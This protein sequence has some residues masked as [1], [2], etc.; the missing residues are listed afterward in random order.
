MNLFLESIIRYNELVVESDEEM[1]KLE[2]KAS[3]GDAQAKEALKRMKI[4]TGKISLAPRKHTTKLRNRDSGELLRQHSRNHIRAM[5]IMDRN[6]HPVHSG[7]LSDESM[8]KY[9]R[10]QTVIAR[11][12]NRASADIARGNRPDI[13]IP[14][15]RALKLQRAKARMHKLQPEN[16]ERIKRL[17]DLAT[18]AR[19]QSMDRQVMGELRPRGTSFKA[20]ADKYK[21]HNYYP[22]FGRAKW[23]KP[24]EKK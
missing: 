1:R 6:V 13:A 23:K 2:R 7:D 8:N 20:L 16:K 12:S 4:R 14:E 24:E 18:R 5:R 19:F 15:R 3:S 10:I 9:D 11:L 17:G 21:E 22:S